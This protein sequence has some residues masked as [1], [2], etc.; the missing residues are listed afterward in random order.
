[1]SALSHLEHSF[2]FHILALCF[3]EMEAAGLVFGAT[4]F[5]A[6]LFSASVDCFNF[7]DSCRAYGRDYEMVLTKLD[8]EKTRLLQWGH[9]VGLCSGDPQN[10]VPGLDSNQMVERVLNCI[11]LLLTDADKLRSKYGME[12]SEVSSSA[13]SGDMAVTSVSRSRLLDFTKKY[14]DFRRH[15][16]LRQKRTST[17][18]KMAWAIRESS[19]FALLVNDLREYINGLYEIAQVPSRDQRNMVR[20]DIGHLSADLGTLTLV[21]MACS[22]R[23]DD[24]SEIASMQVQASERGTQDG[25]EIMEWREGTTMPRQRNRQARIPRLR[26]RDRSPISNTLRPGDDALEQHLIRYGISLE[27]RNSL[28]DMDNSKPG[29]F[30]YIGLMLREEQPSLLSS[31]FSYEAYYRFEKI[32]RVQTGTVAEDSLIFLLTGD[33]D[34]ECFARGIRFSL[35]KNLTDGKLPRA[36]PDLF[37]GAVSD[38]LEQ[39]ILNDLSRLIVPSMTEDCPIA[40]NFFLEVASKNDSAKALKSIAS[41]FGALG[42]RGILSLQNWGKD[43]QSPDGNAYTFT[44]TFFDGMLYIYAT[45]PRTSSG[46]IYSTE[47]RTTLLGSWVLTACLEDFQRGMIAL[48]NIFALAETMRKDLIAAANRTSL[49]IRNSGTHLSDSIG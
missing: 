34:P 18:A 1:M 38:S 33:T 43:E 3:G 16:A 37:S 20:E 21:E 44:S 23:G 36:C 14:A 19:R 7:V 31:S 2:F 47:Y 40:P 42:A 35:Y 30:D 4:G 5:A 32:N 12:T 8:I 29:N 22:D 13:P 24:W 6:A 17:S 48:H 28:R 45:Y 41:Y 27:G 26:F 10:G 25:G 46:L 11:C 9:G 49:S 15:I 39:D